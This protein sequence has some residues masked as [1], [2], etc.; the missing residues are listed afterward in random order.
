[1]RL[2]FSLLVAGALSLLRRRRV[3]RGL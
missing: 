1:M 3:L 2:L